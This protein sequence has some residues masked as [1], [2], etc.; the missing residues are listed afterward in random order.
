MSTQAESIFTQGP[1]E[2]VRH[3]D[4]LPWT[5]IG[6]A[7]SAMAA[8]YVSSDRFIGLPFFALFLVLSKF[9]NWRLPR[10]FLI[11]YGSR[12]IIFAVVLTLIDRT[13]PYDVTVWYLKQ[14]DTNLAGYALAVDLMLRAWERRDAAAAREGLGVVVLITAL[15]FAAATNTYERLHIELLTP[16]YVIC[17][18]L[19]LRSFALMQQSPTTSRTM[20][21]ALVILRCVVILL[22]L[23]FAF[24]GVYL[25][26]RY[27]YQVTSWAM[28]F[29][30]QRH[31][32]HHEIGFSASPLLTRLSNP[33][34]STSRV[35]VIDGQITEPNLRVAAFDDYQK[36]HWGPSIT[37]RDFKPIQNGT[38]ATASKTHVLKITRLGDTADL[39]AAPLGSVQ[40]D[41]EDP[42]EKDA[43]GTIRDNRSG[44]L[45][46]YSVL[47]ASSPT[48]Q[49]MLSVE[50]DAKH[51]EKLLAVPPEVDS[52][53]IDLARNVAGTGEHARQMYRIQEYLRSHHAYSLSFDPQGEP[54]ND[55][56]LNNRAADCQYFASAMVIMARAIGVP[57]RYVGGF[58]AHEPYGD[59][60]TVVRMR[61]AHAWAECW[62][63]GVGWVTADAT[64]SSGRPDAAFPDPPA[65]ERWWEKLTDLPGEIRD[66][67]SNHAIL[68]EELAGAVAVVGVI[69]RMVRGFLQRRLPNRAMP[70]PEPSAELAQLAKRYERWLKLRGIPCPPESTWRA[71]LAAKKDVPAQDLW[72]SGEQAQ[73]C[74]S[75]VRTYDRARFGFD[76]AD[77]AARAHELLSRIENY[78]A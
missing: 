39:E 9:S 25:V 45:R 78:S 31:G 48:F 43:S 35:L 42:L 68:L 53:V 33:E 13:D 54:L 50:P 29:V 2:S 65:W 15:L 28:R 16:I 76:D 55:F 64:P 27:E 57:S 7:L 59:N 6:A 74:D 58:Y 30:R 47:D 62:L 56:I 61:D 4:A 69:V 1:S 12:A 77:S 17:L 49:G 34:P 38:T 44:S 75:F 41:C 20:R 24:T 3:G 63:D 52:K 5:L 18:L 21:P 22:T 71:H 37:E 32:E 23:G 72:P 60:Q 73:L 67:I 10:Y 14:A 66:W 11:T 19:A 8:L 26:A 36:A 46:P 40:V 51:R 70:Y